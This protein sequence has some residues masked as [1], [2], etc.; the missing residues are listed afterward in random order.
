MGGQDLAGLKF[1]D[2]DG[3]LVGDG[4]DFLAAVGGADAEVVH[5][6]GVADADLAAGVDMVITQ[7]V[8]AVRG[9]C[10]ASFGQGP[11]GLAGSGTLQCPVR[12][13]LVVVL[14]EGIQLALQVWQGGGGRLLGQ[15]AFL[16][17][18][19]P[20]DAPMLSRGFAVGWRAG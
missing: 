20:L 15:P 7:P 16:G 17:L 1:G 2:R 8:V 10:G 18:E 6:A 3:G 19:E 9:G 11:V 4:E 14:A 5:A 12:A 13:V